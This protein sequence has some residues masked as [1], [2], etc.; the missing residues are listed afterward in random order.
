MGI[1]LSINQSFNLIQEIQLVHALTESKF[2]ICLPP[3]ELAKFEILMNK[4]VVPL[5]A[6][7]PEACDIT[8]FLKVSHEKPRTSIGGLARPLILPH[9]I[10]DYCRSIWAQER[11][12]RYSFQG[13][14]TTKRR[15]VIEDWVR[16]NIHGDWMR[17]TVGRNILSRLKR[18]VL[19]KVGARQHDVIEVGD[20][21]LSSSNR[22]K[23]FRVKAWDDRYFSV[24]ANSQFVLCPA[25]AWSW[26][27]RFFES[28][29]CGAMPI[30]EQ[31]CRVYE[32]FR[33]YTFE[34]AAA[35]LHWS[36]E[37]AEFNYRVCFERLT[38]PVRELDLEL[39]RISVGGG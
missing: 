30:V 11:S 34:D 21:R 37:D 24:L 28:I 18:L 19:S 5:Q 2:E 22:G 6:S 13:L 25:G 16:R 32:G 36:K 1:R 14:M 38:V 4:F 26:S 15:E 7:T 35:G 27:Y 23:T 10:V 9:A 29:L 39:G 17:L 3:R 33:F 20:L 12:F 31:S 8:T